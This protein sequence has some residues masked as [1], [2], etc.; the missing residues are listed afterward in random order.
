VAPDIK[1]SKVLHHI[2]AVLFQHFKS[3][4]YAQVNNFLLSLLISNKDLHKIPKYNIIFILQKKRTDVWYP[5]FILVCE[6]GGGG[7]V[8]LF[9]QNAQVFFC[10]TTI[11][12]SCTFV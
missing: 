3:C 11:I 2:A 7:G 8:F 1:V 5:I 12:I 4:E 10:N 9:T 6:G